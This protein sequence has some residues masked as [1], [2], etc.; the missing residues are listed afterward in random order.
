MGLHISYI[1]TFRKTEVS[2]NAGF[3]VGRKVKTLSRLG[4]EAVSYSRNQSQ[5]GLHLLSQERD[6]TGTCRIGKAGVV[7]SCDQVGLPIFET[8]TL[9]ATAGFPRGRKHV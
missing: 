9:I 1:P 7:L 6:Y 4:I 3:D 5:T 2:P 8:Q